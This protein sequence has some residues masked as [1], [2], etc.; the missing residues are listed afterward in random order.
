MAP[1]HVLA[2]ELVQMSSIEER[3]KK[4]VVEQLGVKESV[5]SLSINIYKSFYY[6]NT[7]EIPRELSCA[8]MTSSNVKITCYFQK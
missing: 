2:E 4:I 1:A 7:S 8:N 3:V 5:T 6:V